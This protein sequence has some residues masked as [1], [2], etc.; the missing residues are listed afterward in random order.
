MDY[1]PKY[2]KKVVAYIKRTLYQ[3]NFRIDKE[4]NEC[5]LCKNLD[6]MNTVQNMLFRG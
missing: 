4:M 1:S 6:N 2:V 5:P 3:A